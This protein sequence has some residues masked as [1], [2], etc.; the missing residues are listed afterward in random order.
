MVSNKLKSFN[1]RNLSIY[2]NTYNSCWYMV[3]VTARKLNHHNKLYTAYCICTMLKD[4]KI[5]FTGYLD[6]HTLIPLC[7]PIIHYHHNTVCN[8]LLINKYPS[9]PLFSPPLPSSPPSLSLPSFLS[10]PSSHCI[11]CVLLLCSGKDGENEDQ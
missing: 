6:I 11:W 7:N 8:V 9:S 5:F 1:I 2:P 10:H 3:R 4:S